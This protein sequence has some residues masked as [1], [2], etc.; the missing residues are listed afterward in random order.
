MNLNCCM[1]KGLCEIAQVMA[2]QKQ[3]QF[4][5]P[6]LLVVRLLARAQGAGARGSSS[7]TPHGVTASMVWRAKQSQFAARL[8]CTLVGWAF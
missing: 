6:G 3:S 4:M 8:G 7:E 5:L 2:L 1:G